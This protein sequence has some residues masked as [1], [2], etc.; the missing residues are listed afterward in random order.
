MI[1][2]SD[3]VK[4]Q[5]EIDNKKYDTFKKIYTIIEKKIILAS[6][7]NNYS[8][9]YEVPTFLVGVS[10]YSL[11]ECKKYLRHQLKKNGFKSKFHEPNILI[12]NWYP[13]EDDNKK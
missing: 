6:N 10:L 4:K 2:A 9:T 3:L 12:V 1:K 7:G 13:N 8:I 11:N 5:K